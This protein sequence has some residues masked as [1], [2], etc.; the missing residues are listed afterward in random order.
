MSEATGGC[1]RI[2]R[3]RDMRRALQQVAGKMANAGSDRRL[4]PFPTIDCL[5][6][7]QANRLPDVG[8]RLGTPNFASGLCGPTSQTQ[9]RATRRAALGQVEWRS[10]SAGVDRRH[11]FRKVAH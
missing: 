2:D 1:Q 8:A 7:W 10:D 4:K 5:D 6:V 11:E 3:P 9:A